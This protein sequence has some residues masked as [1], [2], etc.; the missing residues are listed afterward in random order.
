M[1]T[2]IA[3]PFC[4]AACIFLLILD[5]RTAIIGAQDGVNMCLTAVVPSIFPFLVLSGFLT[6][7][8]R[9]ANAYLL[10]PLS[11]LLGI[12]KG[13]EGIF[14]T[15]VL[16]GYPIGAQEVHT[17]WSNGQLNIVQANRMLS[18][19]NNAGPAFL[20]GI[21]GAQFPEYWMLWLL[22][23]IQILS[24]ILISLILPGRSNNSDFQGQSNPIS[25]VYALKRGVSTMG[26]ICGWIILFRI[27][28]AFLDRWLLWLF[29]T[30]IQVM[31]CGFLELANGCCSVNSIGSV[32]LRFIISSAVLTFGGICVLMQTASIIKGLSIRRYLLGKTLQVIISVWLAVLAQNLLFPAEYKIPFSNSITMIIAVILIIFFIICKKI[33]KKSSIPAAAVV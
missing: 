1:K 2:R 33:Q 32:G 27:L 14:L 13:T 21:L 9:G 10:R 24:S 20:F 5:A 31:I 19:C 15:G 4:A 18:F 17:A 26:Y 12:P 28:I 16:G 22:W 7:S 3:F 6:S 30:S 23:G 11:R 8:I 29:P 25:F